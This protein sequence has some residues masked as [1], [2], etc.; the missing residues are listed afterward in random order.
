MEA[1]ISTFFETTDL[2]II[3]FGSILFIIVIIEFFNHK[4]KF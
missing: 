2:G 4:P 1:I 3:L